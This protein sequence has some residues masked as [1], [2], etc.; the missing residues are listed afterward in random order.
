MVMFMQLYT[1]ENSKHLFE[2]GIVLLLKK[3][4]KKF[5]VRN[6]SFPVTIKTRKSREKIAKFRITHFARNMARPEAKSWRI[7]PAERM[8]GRSDSSYEN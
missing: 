7:I 1:Y 6:I 4:D 2:I 3:S 5:L 8:K